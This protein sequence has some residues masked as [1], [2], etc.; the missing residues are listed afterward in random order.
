MLLLLLPSIT[1]L[2]PSLSLALL[3]SHIAEPGGEELSLVLLLW[4][5]VD[6]AGAALLLLLLSLLLLLLLLLLLA[7]VAAVPG[8]VLAVPAQ[9]EVEPCLAPAYFLIAQF[10]ASHTL[11]NLAQSAGGFS[12]LAAAG[13]FFNG[14]I[15]YFYYFIDLILMVGWMMCYRCELLKQCIK[16]SRPERALHYFLLIALGLF[17][18]IGLEHGQPFANWIDVLAFCLLLTAYFFAWLFA[19]SVNDVV[20]IDIDRISN[21]NRPLVTEKI[22]KKEM[23]GVGTFFLI[24]SLVGAYLIGPWAFFSIIMFTAAYYIYSAPPLRLK[25]VPLVGTFLISLACLSAVTAG[26]YFA[27]GIQLASAFPAR[28]ILI[29]LLGFTLAAN[30]KDIKDVDGDRAEGIATIPT[31]FKGHTGKAI[32]GAMLAIAFFRCRRSS[33]RQGFLFHRSLPPRWD[34]IL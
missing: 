28:L 32:V 18:A 5:A 30:I 31:I 34:I 13:T 26:F 19:I 25:R 11:T 27:S 24:W 22:S 2:L 3:L 4:V 8:T 21:K 14:G 20:D 33:V 15:A 1:A 7:C 17:T 10:A 12:Y 9:C 6:V 23:Q 16:N 29:V